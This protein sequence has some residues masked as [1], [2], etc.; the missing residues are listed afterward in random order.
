MASL[1][2]T[3][4]DDLVVAGV[5]TLSHEKVGAHALLV[6]RIASPDEPSFEIVLA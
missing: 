4:P 2:F 6:H 5:H 1:V 3:G